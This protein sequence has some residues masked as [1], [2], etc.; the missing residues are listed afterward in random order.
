[1]GLEDDIAAQLD[2]GDLRGAAERAV[3]GY[4]PEVLGF[5]VTTLRDE[6]DAREAFAQ[7]SVDLWAGL[8]TFRRDASVRTWFYALGRHAAARLRRAAYRKPGRHAPVSEAEAIAEQ[9]RSRTLPH[10][11]TEAKDALAE[12]RAALDPED[13]ALLVLRVDRGMKWSEVA[14]VMAEDEGSPDSSRAE[15]RLRKRFQ[16]LKDEIRER[17]AALGL[18]R[19]PDV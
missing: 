12:V 18:T 14:A 1:V 17:C 9:V 19:D 16:V 8:P 7:A 5:L 3:S 6:E 11:R 13:R 15:A 10:L 4:G 2:A